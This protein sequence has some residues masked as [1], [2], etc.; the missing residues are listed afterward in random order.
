MWPCALYLCE[1]YWDAPSSTVA[2]AYSF[3]KSQITGQKA[4]PA[5]HKKVSLQ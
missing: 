3:I 1:Q 2:H 4:D 5:D